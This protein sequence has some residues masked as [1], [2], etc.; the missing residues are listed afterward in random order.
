[1]IPVWKDE[2]HEELDY[3]VRLYTVK[4]FKDGGFQTSTKVEVYRET[5]VEYYNWNNSLMVDREPESYLR[6]EDNNG[7]V[8]G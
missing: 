2:E 3:V 7:D 1:M 5:G 6:L 8:Q 4:E